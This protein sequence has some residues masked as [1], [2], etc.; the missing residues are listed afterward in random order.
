MP[1]E[2]D[3]DWEGEESEDEEE[4]FHDLDW[5]L[6]GGF[7]AVGGAGRCFSDYSK[8]DAPLCRAF[9]DLFEFLI[10]KICIYVAVL[11]LSVYEAIF[12]RSTTNRP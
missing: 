1:K 10:L 6:C 7:T 5:V 4:F 8:E 11:L 12:A 9:V 2:P 3:E